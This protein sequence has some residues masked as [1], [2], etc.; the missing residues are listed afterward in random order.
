MLALRIVFEHPELSKHPKVLCTAACA[1]KAWR[2]A[3]QQCSACNTEVLMDLSRSLLQLRSFSSWL[4]N[5]AGLVKSI[6]ISRSYQLYGSIH[7]LPAEEHCSTAFQL[8]QQAMQMAAPTATQRAAC[9]PD[10][11]AG[12]QLQQQQQQQRQGLR[13]T[14]YR[15]GCLSRP[16]AVGVLSALPAHSLTQLDLSLFQRAPGSTLDASA[17]SAAVAQLS[18][19]QQLRLSTSNKSS[20]TGNCLA[21]VPQLS[22]LTSLALHGNWWGS[23]EMLQQLLSQPLPLQQL[24]IIRYPYDAPQELAVLDLV[25]MTQFTDL[26]SYG[27]GFA[28]GSVL[29][30]QLQRFEADAPQPHLLSALLPLKQLQWL[31]LYVGFPDQQPL[32]RLA[33]LPALQHISLQYTAA[34]AAAG[35]TA[36]WPQLPQLRELDISGYD[37]D[38]PEPSETAAILDAVA[39]CSGLTNLW[40][41]VLEE[42]TESSKDEQVSAACGKLAGLTN[43]QELCIDLKSELAPGTAIALTALTGLTSLSLNNQMSAVD[44]ATAAALA[45]SLTQ[46]QHLELEGCELGSM[47]CLAAIGKLVHLTFLSID[48][49]VDPD[50]CNCGR[51]TREGLMQ[52]TGLTRL[53]HLEVIGRQNNK[54]I[55]ASDVGEFWATVQ[56][57]RREQGYSGSRTMTE[58][59]YES[60]YDWQMPWL[61]DME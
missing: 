43:L 1:C 14:S 42:P 47:T 12:L 9:L 34:S 15:S 40:L 30:A 31:R 2:K 54:E 24:F 19:L 37:I 53:Q 6:S 39:R 45:R 5:H 33:Q 26:K 11:F 4:R 22:R 41:Q 55:T 59:S 36:T 61:R 56:D 21:S 8:L 18:S 28:E 38:A 44:D 46:L 16:G 57:A 35:A 25:R 23:D 49:H 29:P 7:G 13:M 50:V 51:L 60:A 3:V 32:L 58:S 17:V 27:W 10:T 20:S 52:L 48:T